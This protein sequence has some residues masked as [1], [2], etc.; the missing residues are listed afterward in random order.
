MDFSLSSEQEMLRNE[1][2]KFLDK[3]CPESLVRE[4][5]K[6][7]DGYSPE[8]W[9]KIADLGWLGMVFPEEYGGLGSSVLDLAVLY[10]EF[11][12]AMFP[13]PHLSTVVL[14]GLLLASAGNEEQKKEIL[15]RIAKGDLILA[16]AWTEPEA[17]LGSTAWEP[18]GVT[19]SA[20]PDGNDYIVTGTKLFVHDAHIADYLLCVA[21]TKREGP[22]EEGISLFLV[23]AKSP[24][25]KRTLLKTTAGDKQCEVI[26]DTVRIP[27]K[28]LVG[29]LNGGWGPLFQALQRGAVMLCAQMVGAGKEI[30]KITVEYAKT[31]I[32]FDAPI[33]VNQYVQEHCTELASYVDGCRFVTYQA[34]WRL[35]EQL[36]CDFEVAIAKGWCSDA[37]EAACL[38]A[39]SVFAGYGY[40][41]KDGVLPLYSRRGKTQ[42]LYLG[43]G[44]F[45]RKRIADALDTRTFQKPKGKA[46][47]LWKGGPEDEIP[48]WKVWR[49][50]DLQEV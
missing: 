19:V 23:D 25:M 49:R 11:G 30:L 42:Q 16:L 13:S 43:D 31:R 21:R 45:W 39:H 28:N 35:A 26:F 33:G 22:A 46:L 34:A 4:I 18:A 15:P 29:K 32:Q 36:P 47:G 48:A 8:L 38:C 50:E 40:T 20:V 7:R 10:E 5:E 37:F 44:P 3:E 12:K 9:R 27:G 17:S 14:C 6:R 2:R 41:S 24:G 1:A